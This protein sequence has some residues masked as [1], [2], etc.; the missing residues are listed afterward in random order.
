MTKKHII[1]ILL[2]SSLFFS[3]SSNVGFRKYGSEKHDRIPVCKPR[4]HNVFPHDPNAFTQGLFYTDGFLYESTGLNGKSSLRKVDIK[5]GMVVQQIN[6]AADYFGEGITLSK[7]KIIL[8]TWKNKQGF[9]YDKNTFQLIDEFSY[10]TEGWG[11]TFDGQYLIM[12][13]GTDALYYLN[14]DDYSLVKK[15][16]VSEAG[17]AM[18]NLNEL[19]YINGKI[20]A[21]VWKTARIAIIE[22][23]GRVVG[24]ID[25]QEIL[26]NMDCPGKID[27][28]NGID[29]DADEDMIYVTGKY[30]C[31][32]FQISKTIDLTY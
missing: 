17:K 13:D 21:N 10:P 7:N 8:L 5:T 4:I 28:L 19:E 14:P 25:F 18:Y 23:D 15:V 31:K 2:I 9:V 1:L 30:W 27:M 16:N 3:C 12:S 11:I 29:Y 26:Q 6:L 24:W 32:L 22:P 20:Y